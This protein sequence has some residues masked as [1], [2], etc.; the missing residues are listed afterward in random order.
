M[1][2]HSTGDVR[3]GKRGPKFKYGMNEVAIGMTV[4][5]HKLT[6]RGFNYSFQNGALS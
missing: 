2:T 3:V 4:V 5:T 6:E 1:F